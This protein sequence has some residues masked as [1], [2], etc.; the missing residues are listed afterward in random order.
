MEKVSKILNNRQTTDAATW[1]CKKSQGKHTNEHQFINSWTSSSQ[2]NQFFTPLSEKFSGANIWIS[3]MMK[4]K[5]WIPWSWSKSANCIT[6]LQKIIYPCS[7]LKNYRN[8]SSMSQLPHLND[9][10]LIF[11]SICQSQVYNLNVK[12]SGR[13]R[14][15]DWQMGLNW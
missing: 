2:L 7:C 13:I 5:V 10:F 14:K 4:R 8:C 12:V 9:Q 15:E 1:A 11:Y 3:S 6:S